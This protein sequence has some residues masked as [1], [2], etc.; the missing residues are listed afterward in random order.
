VSLI[1]IIGIRLRQL[2][3][4]KKIFKQ[5]RNP[6]FGKSNPE[7][8]NLAFWEWMILAY[9]NPPK[10]GDRYARTWGVISRNGINKSVH[11]PWKARDYFGILDSREDAP[12]WTFHAR[13]G[14]TSTELSDGR[15]IF[16]GGEH[17]DYYDPDF[18]IYNDVIV[19]NPNDSIDIYGYPKKIF[20][21]TDFH[22]A[23]LLYDEIIIIGNFGY[24]EDRR[25]GE[26]QVCLLNIKN[27]KIKQ[28][29]TFG[30]KPGWIHGHSAL[31]T[32][33]KKSIIIKNGEIDIGEDWPLI[34]NIDE[35]KLL[36]DD[37]KW[38]R[39]TNRNWVRWEVTRIDQ[40]ANKLLEIRI[41]LAYFEGKW[42]DSYNK[43]I[44]KLKKEIGK[45]PD[46]NILR[47][48][49]KP[50]ILH[51]QIPEYEEENE[52]HRIKIDNVIVRYVEDSWS[53]QVT[54]EGELPEKTINI[55]KSD[56]VEK[57]SLLENTKYELRLIKNV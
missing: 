38:E 22:S 5:Q 30:E 8:M 26:I 47:S 16:I 45:I 9:P 28:I 10:E 2:E 23:T 25:I 32:K 53:I 31:L 39:M 40:K 20:P 3:I 14:Y 51:H 4:D 18:Y 48:L 29:K 15:T 27:F 35:W 49:Y 57:L 12:I 7:R 55:L 50:K 54:V 13:D 56:L 11:G 1:F 36:I 52:V 21:Q 34:E 33:D 41:A 37:W 42:E 46:F 43:A 44:N 19:F 24:P 6:R 17:E